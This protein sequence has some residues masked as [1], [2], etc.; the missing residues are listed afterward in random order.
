MLVGVVAA[1]SLGGR[2]CGLLAAGVATV[3]FVVFFVAEQDADAR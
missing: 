3:V 2:L 1:T